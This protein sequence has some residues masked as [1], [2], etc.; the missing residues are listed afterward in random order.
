MA[1]TLLIVSGNAWAQHGYDGAPV[2]QNRS[3]PA[4]HV[5]FVYEA[6]LGC[7]SG[8]ISLDAICR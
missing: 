4:I 8:R 7:A 3:A 1:H 2:L 6:Y 5:I